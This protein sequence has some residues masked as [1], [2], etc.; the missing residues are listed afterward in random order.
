MADLAAQPLFVRLLT[1]NRSVLNTSGTS[2]YSHRVS[3][4]HPHGLPSLDSNAHPTA[5]PMPPLRARRPGISFHPDRPTHAPTLPK[6]VS[7]EP[8]SASDTTDDAVGEIP[9][10]GSRETFERSGGEPVEMADQEIESDKSSERFAA[11]SSP[12]SVMDELRRAL[13]P[14]Q[15]PS[16]WRRHRAVHCRQLLRSCLR[17]AHLASRGVAPLYS[18]LAPWWTRVP[19]GRAHP[20]EHHMTVVTTCPTG[21]HLGPC[22]GLPRL[23]A[24]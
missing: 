23:L 3:L 6:W 11:E 7:L 9:S 16:G 18:G 2:T 10:G 13:P 15:L 20:V 19:T 24:P 17:A 1:N 14:L 12:D 5:R 4:L 22:E 8:D 21:S